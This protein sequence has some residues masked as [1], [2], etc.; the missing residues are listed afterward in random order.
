MA[1]AGSTR[2]V[3]RCRCWVARGSA[4]CVAT[5][6]AQV[7]PLVCGPG[8]APA[9]IREVPLPILVEGGASSGECPGRAGG[10]DTATARARGP[11]VSALPIPVGTPLLPL[12]GV[13][14]VWPSTAPPLA[15]SAQNTLGCGRV[16]CPPSPFRSS[17]RRVIWA[18]PTPPFAA[19]LSPPLSSAATGRAQLR[20]PV[21]CWDVLRSRAG[22][23]A[24]PPES[25]PPV[26]A[27]PLPIPLEVGAPSGVCPLGA[28]GVA[29]AGGQTPGPPAT[30]LP[31][32][33]ARPLF[34]PL[35]GTLRAGPARLP[36][37]PPATPGLGAVVSAGV[38]AAGGRLSSGSTMPKRSLAYCGMR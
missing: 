6:S 20:S 13:L 30:S 38:G 31:V 3:E 17:I 7:W 23:A 12:G 34:S 8:T 33:G 36:P 28:G 15:P 24:H 37:N 14:R 9:T 32:S 1:G 16:S 27:G 4:V 10:A 25:P 35:V 2:L 26:R 29:Q 11:P 19:A 22:G 18:V 21:R 5:I